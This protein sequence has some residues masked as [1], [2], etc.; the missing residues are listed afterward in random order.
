MALPE[1]LY[2]YCSLDTF[3]KIIGNRTLWLS[4]IGKSN[5]SQELKWLKN[6][7]HA[8]ILK[9]QI[10]FLKQHKDDPETTYDIEAMEQI[11]DFAKSVSQVDVYKSWAICFSEARDMLSQWRGYAND[12]AGVCIG[13]KRE[14]LEEFGHVFD[15]FQTRFL[16]GLKQVDYSPEGIDKFFESTTK[17]NQ[18]GKCKNAEEM[19]ESLLS[20]VVSAAKNAAYYKNPCF[21]EEREWRLALT[22]TLL[23]FTGFEFDKMPRTKS[24]VF[25]RFVFQKADCIANG[26]DII[27]HIELW[28]PEMHEAISEII[29]GPKVQMSLDDMRL[30]LVLKGFLKNMNDNAISIVRSNSS[31]R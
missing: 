1:T 19:A 20:A 2:H 17:L 7:C 24:G 22:D 30:F 15:E 6:E 13:F 4:D 14:Y 26:N 25:N 21:S 23:N 8:R 3:L 11:A 28:L 29:I 18:F 16:L 9:A 12:G 27:S 5:D 10:G 31:Y